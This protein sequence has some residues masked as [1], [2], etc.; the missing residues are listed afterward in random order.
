MVIIIRGFIILART[1]FSW[2]LISQT[3][4]LNSFNSLDHSN[5]RICR[6]NLNELHGFLLLSWVALCF[7][8]LNLLIAPSNFVFHQLPTH[9]WVHCL[10]LAWWYFIIHPRPLA[11]W[12]FHYIFNHYY[13]AFVLDWFGNLM[14]IHLEGLQRG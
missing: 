8:Y 13:F 2:I 6:R 4:A 14:I 10:I 9:C 1:Y 12:L 11:C 5:K 7:I 3:F